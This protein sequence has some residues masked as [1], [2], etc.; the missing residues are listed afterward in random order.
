MIRVLI[1]D[2][3][4]V[5]REL[6]EHLL[7][8]D[9][10]I[11][12]V[13]CAADGVE[14]L[15]FLARS[16]PDLITMDVRM[17]GMDGFETTRRI[18][19]EH[20]I[21]VVIVTESVDPKLDATVFRALEAGALAILRRPPGVDHPDHGQ[22]AAELV[23]T[24]KLM[25]EV[26]VVRRGA[27]A[28]P[29][30]PP[31][32]ASRVPPVVRSGVEVVAIGASAGGPIA[33]R[34]ILSALPRDFPAPLLVVQHMAQGFTEG[35]VEWLAGYCALR[36][37]VGED[38]EPLLPGTAYLAPGG[39]QMGVDPLGRIRLTPGGPG[40]IHCPSV[41]HLFNSVARVYGRHAIGVLL[42]GMGGDGAEGMREIRARGGVTIAQDS[43]SSVVYGMAAEAVKLKG[44]QHLLP[45]ERIVLLL[46]SLAGGQG[47]GAHGSA[48]KEV[49]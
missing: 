35:F 19:N 31:L 33:V 30:P 32:S 15:A 2:D 26:R 7:N 36:V 43:E 16:S 20:P 12:V 6:L 17:P 37:K 11:D 5:A 39:V 29:V 23:R 47:S 27:W 38:G 13:G 40:Q 44:V 14:A 25:S 28:R 46:N 4:P 41:S 24:V 18:M 1:V 3:S 49:P 8:A 21:P 34:S 10:E 42:S 9:P 48:S 22:A 45:P